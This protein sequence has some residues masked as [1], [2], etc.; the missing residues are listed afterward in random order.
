MKYIWIYKVDNSLKGI[1]SADNETDAKEKVY[2]KYSNY[3]IKFDNVVLIKAEDY[4]GYDIDH[5]VLEL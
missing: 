1:V 3:G 2:D 5:N 4:K